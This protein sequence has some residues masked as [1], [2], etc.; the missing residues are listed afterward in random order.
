MRKVTLL[1]AILFVTAL[2]NSTA[3]LA[4]SSGSFSASYGA[5]QC[6]ITASDGITWVSRTPVCRRDGEGVIWERGR[7]R[8]YPSLVAGCTQGK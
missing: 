4:Q 1:L 3:V 7:A 6:A 8:D 2:Y 5:T